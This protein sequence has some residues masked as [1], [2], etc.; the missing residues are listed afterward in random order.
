VILR[1]G[2]MKVPFR[3]RRFADRGAA[4]EAP[5]A[6]TRG[7]HESSVQHT[8]GGGTTQNQTLQRR[9]RHALDVA[10][11]EAPHNHSA[12]QYR[13]DGALLLTLFVRIDF[14][15][16]WP[17]GCEREMQDCVATKG[18]LESSERTSTYDWA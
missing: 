3:C 4:A 14:W 13:K 5:L 16:R 7:S 11:T 12:G 10:D 6:S 1:I 8:C 18:W 17:I 15:S 9:E 2:T